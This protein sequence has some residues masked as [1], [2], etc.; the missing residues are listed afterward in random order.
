M[1][2]SSS[3][4]KSPSGQAC[5]ASLIKG[6]IAAARTLSA[7]SSEAE[8]NASARARWF[9]ARAVQRAGG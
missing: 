9:N 4:L 7:D 1:A 8:L 6:Q 3:Q 2:S 5:R